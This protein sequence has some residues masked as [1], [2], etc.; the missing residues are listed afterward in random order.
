MPRRVGLDE[1]YHATAGRGTALH[2]SLDSRH[3]ASAICLAGM[4]EGRAFIQLGLGFWVCLLGRGV[5][6]GRSGTLGQ[7]AG[8]QPAKPHVSLLRRTREV[9]CLVHKTL[10]STIRRNGSTNP[11][12]LSTERNSPMVTT[13]GSHKGSMALSQALH[14]RAVIFRVLCA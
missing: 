9:G 5:G 2:R 6:D 4:T 3:R 7:G 8:G 10:G 1:V 14:W 12:P 13:V 11:L